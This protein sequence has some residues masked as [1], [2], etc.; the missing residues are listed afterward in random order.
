MSFRAQ[1]GNFF[2]ARQEYLEHVF[3]LQPEQDALYLSKA[4]ERVTVHFNFDRPSFVSLRKARGKEISSNVNC[5]A[6]VNT[7]CAVAANTWFPLRYECI[8]STAEQKIKSF[9][10]F[11]ARSLA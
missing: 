3:K 11:S 8:T 4:G 9:A 7:R 2:I 6:F 1:R 5:V 10:A